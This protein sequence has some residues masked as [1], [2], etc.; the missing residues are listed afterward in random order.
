MDLACQQ[1]G[2]LARCERTCANGDVLDAGL[3]DNKL[4]RP[5]GGSTR[6]QHRRAQFEGT[7]Q[8][9]H[10]AATA[11]RMAVGCH[12]SRGAASDRMETS[13]TLDS[14]GP[15][16]SEAMQ[17]LARDQSEAMQALA[18]AE[19]DLDAAG[20]DLDAL[21]TLAA[22]SGCNEGGMLEVFTLRLRLQAAEA[23]ADALAKENEELRRKQSKLEADPCH[24]ARN[25]A[26]SALSEPGELQGEFHTL[27]LSESW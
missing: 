8:S 23:R 11:L 21:L 26:V 2:P 9:L 18:Q 25:Q 12:L 14:P 16:Q 20:K 22:T 10:E 19:S 24:E 7:A 15:D 27:T 13:S 3:D 1:P 4:R 5:A 17:A 6:A